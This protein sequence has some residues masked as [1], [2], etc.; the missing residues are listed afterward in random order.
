MRADAG[1][2]RRVRFSC[3]SNHSSGAAAGSG[4][5]AREAPPNAGARRRRKAAAGAAQPRACRLLACARLRRGPPATGAAAGAG[6]PAAPAPPPARD[7]WRAGAAGAARGGAPRA[8]LGRR[9]AA[10]PYLNVTWQSFGAGSSSSHFTVT[11]PLLSTWSTLRAAP[12][13][14]AA[15]FAA[16][17]AWCA[18][19]Q[20]QRAGGAE[21]AAAGARRARAR[22][23]RQQAARTRRQW[24]SAGT[25]PSWQ[26]EL[27]RPS[28]KVRQL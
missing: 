5:A 10:G 19:G 8:R 18:R 3:Y 13:R 4:A 25:L 27:R 15:R 12:G 21:A 9:P 17:R 22:C 24:V 16:A 23:V 2:C 6:A 28:P 26:G 11:R 1:D 20:R 7:S 14:R